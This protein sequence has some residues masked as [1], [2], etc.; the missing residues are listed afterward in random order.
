MAR[1][2]KWDVKNNQQTKQYRTILGTTDYD[3]PMFGYKSIAL[4]IL[5]IVLS[6]FVIPVISEWLSLDY[7]W[8]FV[9]VGSPIAGFTVSF[10][11]FFI[12]SKKGLG[13]S[14]WV[15]GVLWSIVIGVIYYLLVMNG[16]IL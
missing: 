2:R 14:F 10:S 16:L 13:P 8:I 7:K 11:Q 4:I 5:V 12:N 15:V 6:M 9:I 3:I 1:F